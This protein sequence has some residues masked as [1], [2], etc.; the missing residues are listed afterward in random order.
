VV[1]I[2]KQGLRI[3]EEDALDHVF[4][5][6]VGCDL[7]RRDL[8]SEAKKKGKPWA[9]AKGFDFSAPIGA[10]MPKDDDGLEH[11]FLSSNDTS[12]NISLRVND[13]VRQDSSLDK[14]IWNLPEIIAHLSTYFRLQ[15]GDLLMTGTPSGVGALN[16]G[17][18]VVISC[19]K[20]PPCEFII[21]E[22][23]KS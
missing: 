3:K 16:V 12:Q 14:M 22:A 7:T 21:G 17:D 18:S 11:L 9:T 4:G 23:E 8:Q 10:I 5:Y 19:G 6:A 2:G 20:L 15:P 13:T 1:A